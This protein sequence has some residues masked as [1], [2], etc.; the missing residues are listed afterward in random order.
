MHIDE[1]NGKGIVDSEARLVG[2]VAGLEFD[3]MNWKVTHISAKLADGAVEDFGYKKPRFGSINI[4]IPI[5]VVK[6][7]KDI[8]ALNQ[9]FNDLKN[10]VERR[11]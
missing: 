9:G 6:A 7:V 11:T 10:T 1:L 4:L 2:Y 8:I 5:E 3:V